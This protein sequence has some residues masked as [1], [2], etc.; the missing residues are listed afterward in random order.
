MNEEVSWRRFFGGCLILILLVASGAGVLHRSYLQ[1][2][3]QRTTLESELFIPYWKSVQDKQFK[4]ASTFWLEP[5]PA[6]LRASYE[7]IEVKQGALAKA[8]VSKVTKVARQDA[9]DSFEVR[10]TVEF[11]N[12]YTDVVVYEA[13]EVK[14]GWKIQT[15]RVNGASLLGSGPY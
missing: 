11:S 6:K 15:A 3:A 8:S 13:V 10:T 1:H 14:G 2:E 4:R 9:G 12:G 7:K 5:E